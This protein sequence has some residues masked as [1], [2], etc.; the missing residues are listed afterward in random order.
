MARH[1]GDMD[2]ASTGDIMRGGAGPL[3][4]KHTSRTNE[5][6]SAAPSSN[7]PK[8]VNMSRIDTFTRRLSILDNTGSI[9]KTLDA[10]KEDEDRRKNARKSFWSHG[11][12]GSFNAGSNRSAR[13]SSGG[14]S[15]SSGRDLVDGGRV[16]LPTLARR[17]GGREQSTQSNVRDSIVRDGSRKEFLFRTFVTKLQDHLQRAFNGW[18]DHTNKSSQEYREILPCISVLKKERA[19][20]TEEDMEV[21]L[22]HLKGVK[23]FGDLEQDLQRELVRSLEVE[24]MEEDGVLMRE[25]D[26]G[27]KFYI[28][29]CGKVSVYKGVPD[30]DDLP[31]WRNEHKRLGIFRKGDS[32]GELAL[33]KDGRRGAAII[34]DTETVFAT[35]E[36]ADYLRTVRLVYE[37]NVRERTDFLCRIPAFDSTNLPRL[38]DL[39][40][41]LQYSRF[42]VGK[43][44]A[45]QGEEQ[46]FVYFIITGKVSVQ[47]QL[48]K[49][50]GRKHRAPF[51]RAGMLGNA[52][53][54]RRP[55]KDRHPLWGDA[56]DSPQQQQQN[57]HRSNAKD[58][59]TVILG[60]KGPG[61]IIGEC[62]FLP[63]CVNRASA[64]AK[65]EVETLRL[66][67]QDFQA[68]LNPKTVQQFREVAMAYPSQDIVEVRAQ[69]ACVC[70]CLCVCE[71]A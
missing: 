45:T 10:L 36:K 69:R 16:G 14:M 12:S 58:E 7:K 21:L 24:T 6:F 37:R 47:M 70:V 50:N 42:H 33:I 39:C 44:I 57:E 35:M 46:G 23:F 38:R 51:G 52:A 13:R 65:S 40:M 41:Y 60:W 4:L 20:R 1:V 22:H 59:C 31:R 19:E 55:Q 5:M 11:R 61:D 43:S 68:R 26:V 54:V 62:A 49:S 56:L 34:T 25:G 9:A 67:S 29:L 27:H 64:I 15:S 28:V 53:A 48:P 18:R 71:I 63:G 2:N 32:F 8:A 66:S 17:C 30:E 3:L